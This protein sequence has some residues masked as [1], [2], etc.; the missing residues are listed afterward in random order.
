[1]K[2]AIIFFLVCDMFSTAL[3]LR[4]YNCTFDKKTNETCSTTN[5]TRLCDGLNQQGCYVKIEDRMWYTLD[6]YRSKTQCE[7]DRDSVICNNKP[8]CNV[9]CCDSDYCNNPRGQPLVTPPAEPTPTS[10]S[11][12]PTSGCDFIGV[13]TLHHLA[14]IVIASSLIITAM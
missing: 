2:N 12:G 11:P 4:C 5:G 3:C 1:M 6:C 8:G 10:T 13:K 9:T 14:L 7:T